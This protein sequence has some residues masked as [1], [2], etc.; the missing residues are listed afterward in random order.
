MLL[1]KGDGTFLPGQTF[2]AGGNPRYV[3]VG[4]FNGDG[5]LDLAVANYQSANVSV[6]LGKGDGTFQATVN[7]AAGTRPSSVAVG[8]FNGDG[9]PDLATVSNGVSILL[10]DATWSM[11][12]TGAAD[13]RVDSGPKGP[14]PPSLSLAVA[15]VAASAAGQPPGMAPREAAPPAPG[16]APGLVDALFA[17]PR[18]EDSARAASGLPLIRHAAFRLSR[19]QPLFDDLDL[20]GQPRAPLPGEEL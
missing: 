9:F 14:A 3:A 16:L 11:S 15:V 12:P 17:A 8:D 6:L 20:L 18:G 7:Y 13:R 19:W 5:I 10:N 4:D 2:P 1:G